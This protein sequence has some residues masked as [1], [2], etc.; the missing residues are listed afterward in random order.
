MKFRLAFAGLAVALMMSSLLVRPLKLLAQESATENTKRT[1]RT[2]VAPIY[3][4]LAL[5]NNITGRV[6]I[7]A[8]ISADG[9]VVG[10]RVVGGSPF[11]VNAAL[12]AL[13]QWR[14]EQASK[15]STET[16][17]FHFDKSTTQT[18]SSAP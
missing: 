16:F 12:S 14:F 9:R 17:E 11:L 4:P 18:D 6:K 15:D 5:H 8:T 13:K 3:P 2:K 1:L 7:E 10:T